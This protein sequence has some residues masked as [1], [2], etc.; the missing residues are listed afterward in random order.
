MHKFT[1]SHQL[2]LAL[3]FGLDPVFHRLD[4]MVGGLFDRLDGLA[5]SF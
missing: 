1:G 2:G 5:I 4:V 3:K